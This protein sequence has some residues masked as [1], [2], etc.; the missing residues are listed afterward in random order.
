MPRPVKETNEEYVHNLLLIEHFDFNRVGFRQHFN[1]CA[2]CRRRMAQIIIC[3][4]E[5]ERGK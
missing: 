3:Y 5:K 4:Y 2:M 1:K